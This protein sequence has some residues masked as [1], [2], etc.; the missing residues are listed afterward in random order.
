MPRWYLQGAAIQPFCDALRRWGAQ[1]GAGV[2]GRSGQKVEPCHA[3]IKRVGSKRRLLSD[4]DIVNK[5]NCLAA[6]VS[7]AI[8]LS[9]FARVLHIN[10]LAGVCVKAPWISKHKPV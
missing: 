6:T 8:L 3:K 4:V 9:W 1:V 2:T 5:E 10:G 7:S